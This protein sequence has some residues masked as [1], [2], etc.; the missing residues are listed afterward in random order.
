[1][2]KLDWHGFYLSGT[3]GGKGEMM[4]KKPKFRDF[5]TASM[6]RAKIK[7]EVVPRAC[8]ELDTLS[9]FMVA[10]KFRKGTR[11][12]NDAAELYDAM[13]DYLRDC[14]DRDVQY[15]MA[16]MLLHLNLSRTTFNEYA[17]GK[18]GQEFS[19]M[20][21]A[22]RNVVEAQRSEM[23]LE[24]KKG[25]TTGQIF[26]LKANFGWRDRQDINLNNPDGNLASKVVTVLPAKPGEIS[27]DQWL[28]WYNN[29]MRKPAVEVSSDQ[30]D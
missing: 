10:H 2:G 6:A 28:E 26:D 25:D 22:I 23:L 21:H 3:K 7:A 9:K 29:T 5:K 15:T 27:I 16:G 1:M 17:N 14:E 24:S 13:H 20:A 8:A 18:Y 4:T 19:E 12:Y 30:K 11:K